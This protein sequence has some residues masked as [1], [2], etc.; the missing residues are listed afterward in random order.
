MSKF[1]FRNFKMTLIYSMMNRRKK[2]SFSPKRYADNEGFLSI[3]M[4]SI[5]SIFVLATTVVDAVEGRE[6]KKKPH[7]ETQS[8]GLLLNPRPLTNG[9]NVSRVNGIGKQPM[10]VLARDI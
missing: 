1:T 3:Q 4:T 10:V 6:S 7:N 5:E 9:L 8:F 2:S